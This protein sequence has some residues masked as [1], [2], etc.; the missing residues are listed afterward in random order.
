MAAH[1]YRFGNRHRA[2]V[3]LAAMVIGIW[4]T[5][6]LSFGSASA[7]SGNYQGPAEVHV[8][9]MHE[10]SASEVTASA[11][12][13]TSS[14]VPAFM[15]TTG[16]AEAVRYVSRDVDATIAVIDTGADYHHA[17]LTPYLLNGKNYIQSGTPQDDHGH[18]TAVAGVIVLAAQALE[19]TGNV[20][21]N[22]KIL[23]IKALDKS[24]R[25]EEANLSAAI[26]YAV[27]QKADIIVLSLGLR[28]DASGLREA[29]KHAEN[30]GVMLIAASGNDAALLGSK[31]A[32][33]YPAVYDSVLAVAGSSGL[34]PVR[35]STPGQEVDISASWR[36]ESLSLG[37]GKIFMEGS[38]MS[39]PQVAV[40][41]AMLKAEFA[42]AKPLQIREMLRFTSQRAASGWNTNIGYG[43]LAA[44]QALKAEVKPDWREPNNARTSAGVFPLGK[45]V[46]GQWANARDEDWFVIDIPYKGNLAIYGSPSV[47]VLHGSAGVIAA[48]SS[49]SAGTL[50]EWT[51]APGKYW[52]RTQARSTQT[53][54]Y[55]LTSAFTIAPDDREPNNTSAA[56]YTIQPQSQ[57]WTGTF[58]ERGDEDWFQ[59]RLPEEGQ[60]RLTATADT[61]RMDLELM[62]QPAGGT[63]ILADDNGDGESEWLNV[64]RAS[65]GRY[66][67]RIRNAVSTNPEPVIGTYTVVMEYITP[68]EDAYEPNNDAL[69]ATPL[70]M[71]K[72]YQGLIHAT[73]DEDWYKF[74]ISDSQKTS[75]R[76]G[77]IPATVTATVELR[78][79][80]LQKIIQW[81]NGAGKTE[82]EGSRNLEAGT[83]YLVVK[84]DKAFT[85]QLYNLRMQSTALTAM[86]R[87]DDLNGYAGASHIYKLI[88]AGWINGYADQTFRPE[89]TLTRAE[90]TAILVRAAGSGKKADG[91]RFT[92][93]P[94]GNWA[95][96]AIAKADAAGWLSRYATGPFRP[97]QEITRA[98]AAVLLASGLELK[99]PSRSMQIY[100]DVPV[101]HW[102]A[103]ALD[104]LKQGGWLNN[105]SGD[106]F[107]PDVAITR[108]E[109]AIMLSGMLG[110]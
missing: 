16:L 32:V 78:D 69:A 14:T 77:N 33:Q 109:W 40:A 30:N 35:Q 94:V 57:K 42:D 7:V 19:R 36:V 68:Y 9:G 58:H 97:G 6:L 96:D 99:L 65:A 31:A 70:T 76:V 54:S 105:F 25:G 37:G 66:F 46:A 91:M 1:K 82:I 60:L 22:G 83:Y 10:V 12:T 71:N 61:S 21:W 29:V 75:L 55:R 74:S 47:L 26:R 44:D 49:P 11:T 48:N 23:P 5:M 18:G 100:K 79:R 4:S 50:S 39:A 53:A 8:A 80:K 107:K 13:S 86:N 72:G 89:Q 85:S 28:R 43:F 84:A 64:E 56:A 41:A 62:L 17:D 81:R 24:G 102:S 98:E 38:S 93:V 63:I 59:F 87:F 3:S 110:R 34:T 103:G 92:D 15:N 88:E 95:Y 67:L 104:V 27:Q 73:T 106:N 51:L 52:L 45:E 20:K 101:S 90:A 108:A 2:I